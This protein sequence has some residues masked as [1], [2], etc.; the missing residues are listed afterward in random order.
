MACKSALAI[1]QDAV[2]R[3]RYEHTKKIVI[4][5]ES[6]PSLAIKFYDVCQCAEL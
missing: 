4:G 3:L 1:V 2:S 5:Q 6:A